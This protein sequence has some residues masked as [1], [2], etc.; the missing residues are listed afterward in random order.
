[1]SRIIVDSARPHV[2][3]VDFDALVETYR[4]IKT[5]TRTTSAQHR[6]NKLFPDLL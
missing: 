5:L 1:M 4:A 2:Q 6:T 3:I